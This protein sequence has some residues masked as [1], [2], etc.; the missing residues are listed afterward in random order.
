MQGTSRVLFVAHGRIEQGH[1]AVVGALGEG[2]S[3][4]VDLLR[5]E[6][7][8][9]T[10]ERQQLSRGEALCQHTVPHNRRTQHGH[11][12]ALA[13]QGAVHR[14]GP[15]AEAARGSDLRGEGTWVGIVRGGSREVRALCLGQRT[16]R[17]SG[18]TFFHGCHEAVSIAAEGPDVVLLH[19]V[20]GHSLADHA[21]AMRHDCHGSV[22]SAQPAPGR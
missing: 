2:A 3:I 1:E 14:Q 17:R 22:L 8:A 21:Q 13:C 4:P 20:I 15:A 18:Y 12:F 10:D 5:E 19:P 16:V 9:P 6:G 7:E 11:L